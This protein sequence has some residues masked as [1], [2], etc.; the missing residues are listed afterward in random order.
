MP[1]STSR[2]DCCG[3]PTTIEAGEAMKPYRSH[4]TGEIDLER[5]AHLGDN[6][7]FEAGALVFHP[8]NISIG[9]N[10]YVGHY[11]ILKG[12]YKNELRIGDNVWIGQ[13]CFLHS[14]GGL[15][16]EDNV[17]IG[18]G[19]KAISARHSDGVQSSPLS[20]S[21][22]EFAPI[23]IEA[24]ANIGTGAIL[25]PGVRIGRGAQVGAGAVVV[26]DVLPFSVVAG[27]PAKSLRMR[28]PRGR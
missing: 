27:V 9:S 26:E 13:Q 24:E 20:Q 17:G 15:T 10:V 6:V 18:P 2:R 21:A 5:F 14:A 23:I 19:V 28:D 25:L 11:A 12:Y 4:G 1:E 8:E 7:V 16:I 3:R 22:L